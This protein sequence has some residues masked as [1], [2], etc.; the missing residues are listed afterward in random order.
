MTGKFLT[1]RKAVL[2]ITT[3]AAGGT[4]LA[5]S[6]LVAGA[7][8]PDDPAPTVTAKG[9]SLLN[10][11]SGESLYGKSADTARPTASTAKMMVATVILDKRNVDLDRKVPVQQEYRDYVEEHHSSTA[12][13]Q[14]GDKVT[15][16]QL[17][18]AALL[19]SG[20]DAA[21]ALA[22]TFGNGATRQERVKSFVNEMNLKADQLDLKKTEFTTFDGSKAKDVSTPNELAKLARHAIQK[23]LFKKV[24]KTKKYKCEAPAAN[25]NMRYYTWENT[26]KL[27]SAYKGTIGI[28]TG[29]TS[30]AG[31]NLVF[32]AKRD[33]KTFVGTVMNSKDRFKDA[34]KLLDHAFGADDAKD[35][36]LPES[37]SDA[38]ED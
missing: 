32:A 4:L 30:K 8:T 16:R 23:P 21:Y 35:L 1:A 28:K 36:K 7:I 38:Q 25:G 18:Y 5:V 19:R 37:S 24:V 26:N 22:D 13:L 14:T 31:E 9:A 27:L 34:A 3:L 10:A 29:T 33:G 20:A 12:D 2:G 15:V 17:L 11:K 6:P